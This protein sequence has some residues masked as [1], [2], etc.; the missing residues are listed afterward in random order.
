MYTH[1]PVSYSA[2][3]RG[4]SSC[5]RWGHI[6]RD[7]QPDIFRCVC[8]ERG[9]C[10][11]THS[12]RFFESVST[13]KSFLYGI[14]YRKI[15]IAS[16]SLIHGRAMQKQKKFNQRTERESPISRKRSSR[17]WERGNWSAGSDLQ[18]SEIDDKCISR[19]KQKV[20]NWKTE[21]RRTF[22]QCVERQGETKGD[23]NNQK[24]PLHKIIK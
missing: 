5:S 9:G 12:T 3:M 15:W 2:I 18:W 1:R 16:F 4:T 23:K 14:F 24:K 20:P 10:P 8:G 17:R 11:G 13:D 22:L 6:C 21:V 19:E 7:P